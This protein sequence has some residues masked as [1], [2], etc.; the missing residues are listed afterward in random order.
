MDRIPMTVTG[1]DK[2]Q[3][4]LKHLKSVA[5][6]RII[7][8]IAT[9]RALGDLKENAE[10]HEAKREQS[11][12]EGRIQEIES[13]LSNAQIIDP[14][15][16][17]N[18]GKVIFGSTIILFNLE[19]EEKV[20]YKIV[21]EDEAD[22]K[23]SKISFISPISRALIGKNKGTEVEVVTPKGVVAYEILDVFYET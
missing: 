1:E 14:S 8:A 19:T 22:L 21:G 2:L 6:P 15:T 23:E 3:K 12:I 18:N 9:A 4:E 16:I 10:Y 5:R 13:K 20:T 7:E 11:F 17:S